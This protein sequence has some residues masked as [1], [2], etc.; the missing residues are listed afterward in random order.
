MNVARWDPVRELED[1][2]ERLNRMFARPLARQ[3]NGKERLTVADWVPTVDIEEGEQEYLI[4][5]ELPGIKKEDVKITLQD[6]VLTLHGE[7]K[8]EK[9]EQGKRLHRVERSYGAFV[10]SF[11]LPDVVDEGNVSAEFKDGVLHVRLPKSEKAKPKA[12]EVKVG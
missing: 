6:G 3:E 1:M 5:A 8:Q 10:R 2:S 4:T 9:V 11:A 7:R 12:I